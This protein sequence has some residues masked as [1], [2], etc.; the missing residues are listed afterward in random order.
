LDRGQTAMGSRKL[1]AWLLHP[2]TDLKE[3]ERRQ[4]SVE[5]LID[6]AEAA[7]VLS[8]ILSDIADLERLVSRLS[9]RSA[10]PRDLAGLRNSL[11]HLDALR[12]WLADTQFCSGLAAAASILDELFVPLKE[13]SRLLEAALAENPPA[14]LQDGGI[15]RQGFDAGLDEL[16]AIKDDSR[17][18]LS[19]LEAKERVDT[20]IPS[21]KVA[22]NSVFGYYIEVT[23]PHLPKVPPRYQR[24]QTLANAERF[25]TPELKELES[26]IL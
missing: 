1:R 26:K 8:Q 15:I 18:F 4:N 16:R 6:K 14:K 23:R 10:S 7:R 11:S 22:F 13:C 12:S 17:R 25:L 3:I 24:K 19:E 5:E 9:T 2:S 21:L 20:G